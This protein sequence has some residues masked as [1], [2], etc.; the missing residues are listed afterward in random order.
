MYYEDFK[1]NQVIITPERTVVENELDE[2]IRLSGL[3]NPMFLSDEGGRAAGHTGRIVPGPFQLSL[4]MGLFQKAGVFDHVVAV[5]EFDP[6]RFIR[7]VHIGDTLTLSARVMETSPTSNPDRGKV[8]LDIDLKK[9][10][11]QS[12]MTGRAIYL[13]RHRPGDQ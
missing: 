4:A 11:D 8:V 13:M 12:V 6:L 2:F 1:M 10:D 7:P 5:A 3:V 9:Q